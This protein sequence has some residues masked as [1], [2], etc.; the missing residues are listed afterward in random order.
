M[1]KKIYVEITNNC[2]LNCSFCIGNTR[3]KEYI[4]IDRFK[5]LLKRL[6]GYTDYLYFHLMGEPL[7]HPQINELINYASTK[8]NVNITTN[9]YYIDRIK[10]NKNI[11]Q[12][13]VS[14][15]S[16]DDT[17]NKTLDEYLNNIFESVN[18]LSKNTY[19]SYRMW[20]NN[21][22][23]DEIIEHI[24]E[25]YNIKIDGHTTI[26]DNI[27]F[28]FDSEFIWPDLNNDY[29][30]ENGTC[31]GL[32]THV[33]ILVDGSVVPCCLDYN[34]QLTLGN[35]Y[36]DSLDDILNSD[37]ALDM[38]ESF[39]QNIKNEELCKHCNFYDRIKA[40]QGK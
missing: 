17:K 22:Y 25:Y 9:G 35:I 27:F 37:K 40:N 32:S 23:K 10:D 36:E 34:G 15:H 5:D 29:Y 2:N 8:F 26:R 1:F 31:Q 38:L 4:K 30:N 39:K 20:T 28:D 18:E 24:E 33:G 13:N 3:R 21:K 14:L 19:I 11:R 16:Y 12:I 7:I 6:E